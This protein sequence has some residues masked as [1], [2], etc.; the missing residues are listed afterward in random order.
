MKIYSIDPHN[1]IEF[2]EKKNFNP[3]Y[4]NGQTGEK[5]SL[6][7]NPLG[8]TSRHNAKYSNGNVDMKVVILKDNIPW[9]KVKCSY[10][11]KTGKLAD[12][13]DVKMAGNDDGVEWMKKIKLVRKYLAGLIR[14]F[15]SLNADNLIDARHH[16]IY[17]VASKMIHETRPYEYK[18]SSFERKGHYRKLG[19]K[20]VYVRATTVEIEKED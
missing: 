10:S 1:D 7:W 11:I 9:A 6:M 19:N 13:L 20:C 12:S 17:P 5:L 14:N 4:L 2:E 18:I 16:L 3:V 15:A 8:F